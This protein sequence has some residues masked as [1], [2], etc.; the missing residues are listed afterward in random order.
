MAERKRNGWKSNVAFMHLRKKTSRHRYT[1]ERNSAEQRLCNS[2]IQR[3][4]D[5]FMLSF[6]LLMNQ[7]QIRLYCIF[8]T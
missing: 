2:Q 1:V 7:I 3:T 4:S 5:L 6:D 8:N